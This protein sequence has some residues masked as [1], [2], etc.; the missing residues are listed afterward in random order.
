MKKIDDELARLTRKK[1]QSV[2]NE[3]FYHFLFINVLF[4]FK[5]NVCFIHQLMFFFCIVFLFVVLNVFCFA[6][7]S[8][9]RIQLMLKITNAS[10]EK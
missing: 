6:R 7:L 8:N 10:L 9:K 5:K 1:H 2:R 4:L 3:Y